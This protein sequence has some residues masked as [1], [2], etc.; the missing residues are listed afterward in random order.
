[1]DIDGVILRAVGRATE[2]YR[3]WKEIRD[4]RKPEVRKEMEEA[5]VYKSLERLDFEESMGGKFRTILLGAGPENQ[6]PM[7]LLCNPEEYI[8]FKSLGRTMFG[9]TKRPLAVINFKQ[10]GRDVVALSSD[11]SRKPVEVLETRIQR[12]IKRWSEGIRTEDQ[13]MQFIRVQVIGWL[14]RDYNK[15][16]K[17]ED[18]DPF[19]AATAGAFSKVFG[20]GGEDREMYNS[21]I[22]G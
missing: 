2:K 15:R 22:I 14:L 4:Y 19:I 3:V 12:D 6:K 5:G 8:E 17:P 1:M 13:D 16:I 18:R 21:K 11:L 20:V 10:L 7:A 9:D